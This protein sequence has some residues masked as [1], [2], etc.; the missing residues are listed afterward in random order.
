MRLAAPASGVMKSRCIATSAYLEWIEHPNPDVDHREH[1]LD[2][3]AVTRLE[4][5][6]V[7]HVQDRDPGD[8]GLED[9]AGDAEVLEEGGQRRFGIRRNPGEGFRREDE[10]GSSKRQAHR[11]GR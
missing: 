7:G 6:D 2:P 3:A 11:P 9:A 1:R 8:A 10:R 5:V 4:T